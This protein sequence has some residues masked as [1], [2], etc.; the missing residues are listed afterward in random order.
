MPNKELTVEHC[1][2]RQTQNGMQPS[3][4]GNLLHIRER[5]SSLCIQC[6]YW[7]LPREVPEHIKY[8]SGKGDIV[9]IAVPCGS[10]VERYHQWELLLIK[11]GLEYGVRLDFRDQEYSAILEE[12][13]GIETRFE[14]ATSAVDWLFSHAL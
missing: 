7:Y 8:R 3:Y 2:G 13:R 9:W 14:L 11:G 1:T 5:I 12:N 4:A 10:T 6:G